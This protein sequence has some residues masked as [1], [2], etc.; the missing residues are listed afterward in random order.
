MIKEKLINVLGRLKKNQNKTAKYI[1]CGS[2]ILGVSFGL[3]YK[4]EYINKGVLMSDKT[5][6]QKVEQ[7]VAQ[8][9]YEKAEKMNDIYFNGIDDIENKK[10]VSDMIYICKKTNSTSLNEAKELI[11][12]I[13]ISEKS[14]ISGKYRDIGLWKVTVNVTNNTG[15]FI[16]N[17]KIK[18]EFK[19]N[20]GKIIDTKYENILMDA[21]SATKVT[22]D[23]DW[24]DIR[25]GKEH[26][27]VTLDGIPSLIDK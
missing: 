2:I 27:S 25:D 26:L 20:D 18:F 10:V 3:F 22:T 12:N 6:A 19:D 4:Y 9:Q 1:I 24:I 23:C 14:D 8:K 5:K 21:N 11:K 17:G 16:T 15:K 13:K 7:V